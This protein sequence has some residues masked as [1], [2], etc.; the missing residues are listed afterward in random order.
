MKLKTLHIQSKT[1]GDYFSH[2][3]TKHLGIPFSGKG[4][5]V[6]YLS[7]KGIVL[8]KGKI[9]CSIHYNGM[10]DTYVNQ[11][12]TSEGCEGTFAVGLVSHESYDFGVLQE[13]LH[14]VNSCLM[15]ESIRINQD[16][17]LE[18]LYKGGVTYLQSGPFKPSELR[19]LRGK[20]SYDD[21]TIPV[22]V[23]GK[24]G[25]IPIDG[26]YLLKAIPKKLSAL[27][28]LMSDTVVEI[29][30]N[31]LYDLIQVMGVN[32]LSTIAP[33][34]I[35]KEMNQYKIENKK[36][37]LIHYAGQEHA[38]LYTHGV[39][40]RVGNIRNEL[41]GV[42]PLGDFRLKYYEDVESLFKKLTF[43]EDGH[44]LLNIGK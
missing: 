42:P 17:E 24:L 39:F 38:L 27:S 1:L 11:H 41:L 26:T 34:V 40:Y 36:G 22:K 3:Q 35:F 15:I 2:G 16:L 18:I 9:G 32:A 10:G 43:V 29:D 23:G 12:V 31:C 4:V 30:T 37:V 7:D 6:T 19:P 44:K 33:Y 21:T 8:K 25:S 28:F 14:R 13:H 20:V 5:L